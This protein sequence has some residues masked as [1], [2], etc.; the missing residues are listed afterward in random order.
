MAV[1]I[2]APTSQV[3]NRSG[4][5]SIAWSSTYPQVA[6]EILY[7]RKGASAWSTFGRVE[8]TSK[9]VMLDTTKFNDFEEY[10]FRVIVYT[11]TRMDEAHLY[12]GSDS[13]PA[14]SLIL[15]PSKVHMMKM[16]GSSGMIEVPI[17]PASE[18]VGAPHVGIGGKGNVP[19][20]DVNDPLATDVHTRVN[21]ATKALAGATAKTDPTGVPNETDIDVTVTNYAYTTQAHNYYY[22]YTSYYYYLSSSSATAY[23]PYYT[24]SSGSLYSSYTTGPTYTRSSRYSSGTYYPTYSYSYGVAYYGYYLGYYYG[25]Y[26]YYYLNEAGGKAY[27]GKYGLEYSVKYYYFTH[28][29][30][31]QYTIS[32]S[33]LY[34]AGFVW[35]LS[36]PD[37]ESILCGVYILYEQGCSRYSLLPEGLLPCNL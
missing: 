31:V 30:M 26:E 15:V 2:T 36:G 6:Y 3:V 10:H 22:A 24:S 33:K 14:Y 27:N 34:V 23:K 37:P 4:G 29:Y 17:Y 12:V 9:Q 20:V 16:Q 1:T 8:S 11:N 35:I 18:N 25:Y 7:R 5:V 21:G 13:S 19:L 28:V 32:Y